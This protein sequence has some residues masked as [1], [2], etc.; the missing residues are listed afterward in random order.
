MGE[1][2]TTPPGITNHPE[3]IYCPSDSRSSG[4]LAVLLLKQRQ[5]SS[6]GALLPGSVHPWTGFSRQPEAVRAERC[7]CCWLFCQRTF[8]DTDPS[9]SACKTRTHWKALSHSSRTE[10]EVLELGSGSGVTGCCFSRTTCLNQGCK[11]AV[12]LQLWQLKPHSFSVI[13]GKQAQQKQDERGKQLTL[14]AE[15]PSDDLISVLLSLCLSKLQRELRQFIP[16][17]WECYRHY[18]K[19]AV[20]PS[21]SMSLPELPNKDIEGTGTSHSRWN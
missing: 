16:I 7:L 17:K 14:R 6:A 8:S 13:E 10:G 11:R 5:N 1:A 3:L 21:A 9:G 4:T 20:E 12:S 15:L 19:C 2:L 18:L